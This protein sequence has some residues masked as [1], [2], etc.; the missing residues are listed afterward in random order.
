MHKV[1]LGTACFLFSALSLHAQSPLEKG[2]Q[3]I[4]RTSAEAIVEF[5]A[6]DELQGR[7]AGMHGSRVAARYIV[8]CLKEAGIRPLEK[9]GYYQPFEAYAK[10]RQQRGRW[11]VHPDSV[12]VLKQGTHRSLKMDNV[13]AYIPGKRSDEY[14]IV[15]AHF[16]H[17]GVDET[18]ADDKI[19]NGADDNASGVSAVLQIARAFA[20]SGE[21]PLRNVIFA[22]WDGEEKGL[23]GSK[24]FVQHCPFL[25]QI[26]GYLNFD[27]IGRNN[28]PEQPQHVVYFY[29]A[30]HP[31][32]GEWLKQDITRYGLQL[33][34]DYRPWDNPVGGS[35]NASFARSG[36]P[37]IWY[38]TDGHPDYHQPSDHAALL[39]WEK[40]VEITKASFL[41]VWNLANESN[42]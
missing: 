41:N 29:T 28:K 16:D 37:V 32:F 12:A 4:N 15:G 3:S 21:K 26:K 14:V 22:F 18:L 36:I 25:K 24:H 9:N 39:N 13:L 6:D 7:E 10:E 34:P 17:L 35:D 38:H 33:Q 11:Q 8:S 1:F 19:Y 31:A 23:L 2:L 5:L 27:M 42:Y 20:L 30:A 40:V